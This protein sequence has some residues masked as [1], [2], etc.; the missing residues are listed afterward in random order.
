MDDLSGLQWPTKQGNSNQSQQ[1]QKQQ[2]GS[3]GL[4]PAA[5]GAN[6]AAPNYTPSLASINSV[7]TPAQAQPRASSTKNGKDDP[8]GELVSFSSGNSSSAQQE[9][10]KMTLRE[11][12]QI[13]ESRSNSSSPFSFQQQQQ[14]MAKPAAALGSST[15]NGAS[16][17]ADLWNFDALERAS[18]VSRSNAGTPVQQKSTLNP[19]NTAAGS[20]D[21]D[22]LS[23]DSVQPKAGSNG[24]LSRFDLLSDTPLD[25]PSSS[26]FTTMDNTPAVPKVSDALRKDPFNLGVD[27]NSGEYNAPPPTQ[28]TIPPTSALSD[29]FAD[30][31]YELSQVVEYGFSIEQAR[32]ALEISGS[33]RAAIRLL[34]EQQTAERRVR[35]QQTYRSNKQRNQNSYPDDSA[36]QNISSDD[37]DDGGHYYYDDPRSSAANRRDAKSAEQGVSSM[38][39]N[40]GGADALL[41]TANEIGSSVW[42]QANS[43]FAIG[44]KKIIEMQESMM[45][46]RKPGTSGI[47]GGSSQGW[48]QQ[49]SYVQP[50]QRYRDYDSSSDDDEAAYISANRRGRRAIEKVNNSLAAQSAS[51]TDGGSWDDQDEAILDVESEV[52]SISTTP[53]LGQSQ[54]IAQPSASARSSAPPKPPR[55][56]QQQKPPAKAPPATASVPFISDGALQQANSAKVGA[57]EQFKLGQFGD[58]ISGYT[59]A[60]S[61]VSQHSDRHPLL[62]VLYNNRALSYTRNGE[63]KN[64]LADCSLSLELCDVYQANGA[65]ELGSVGRVDI[66]EQRAKSLNR[67]AEAH[68]S[69]E[70][71]RQAL[72]DWKAL[73]GAARDAGMRQ[74]A[75]RGIQR[76]EKALGISKQPASSAG[77]SSASRSPAPGAVKRPDDDIANVFAAISLNNVKNSGGITILNM[78]TENSVA[79]AEMRRKEQ[80]KQA[81]DDQ[82]LALVD[83]VD[84]ELKRWKDGKQQNLRA[85]LSSLHILLPDFKPIGMHEILEPNKVKRAYMRAISKLHPDKLNKDIDVRTKMVSSS[86]FSSLNE[87]WDA[88]KLQEGIS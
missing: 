39:G 70:K 10:T 48:S 65:I 85:L 41:A 21:F 67:R 20:R 63:A 32:T 35:N 19:A 34:R 38:L 47:S 52:T 56:G 27:D 5:L 79:V 26:S 68:E 86:V 28:N 2:Y 37:S 80:L 49:D 9:H 3:N 88:F 23:F 24:S 33:V 55:V 42:K 61:L 57:N 29:S 15:S 54:F 18:S 62:I 11:R 7:S 66:A 1:Q 31:D 76:C 36:N 40:K 58:A 51:K 83:Q 16:A 74:Q 17:Q 30:R 81:E 72:E 69:E 13:L 25:Q 53:V 6:V 77:L 43:W 75:T 12:Q 59:K 45:D 71:Y 8:F 82:K 64:A 44:K 87:A 14:R 50:A 60:V 78:D 4:E 84:A 22:P 73:R 46:Q